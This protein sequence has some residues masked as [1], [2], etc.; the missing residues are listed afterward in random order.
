MS[1]APRPRAASA[2]LVDVVRV[3]TL[4]GIVAAVVHLL[5]FRPA[6]SLVAV[7]LRGPRDRLRFALRLDLGSGA[8]RELAEM[9]AARME[10]AGADAVILVVF[11]EPADDASDLPGW[12]LVDA[13]GR[14]LTMPVRDALVVTGGR[15]RS[16]LCTDQRCCPPE[17]QVLDADSADAARL[18]A[19]HALHGRAVLPDRESLV[20]SVMPVGGIAAQSVVQATWRAIRRCATDG[21]ERFAEQTR[22]LLPELLARYAEPPATMDDD[23]VGQ[24][25]VGLH[26]RAV[27]DEFVALLLRR[28]G[29]AA[30]GVEAAEALVR[31]LIRRAQPPFDGPACTVF[32]LLAYVNGEGVT[33]TIVLERAV[34]SDPDDAVAAMLLEAIDNQVSPDLVRATVAGR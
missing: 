22:A 1:P 13:V 16:Y 26:D 8:D 15:V 20:A 23:E 27:R 33:A 9:V 4:S 17:G 30:D 5:G 2:P 18:A 3:A 21:P 19:A 34:A 12:A 29:V 14:A 32:G 31:E 6:E 7:A 11:A 24:V 25:V 10:R 28:P